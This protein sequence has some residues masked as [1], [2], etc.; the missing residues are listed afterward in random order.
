MDI[1]G[2]KP[3]KDFMKRKFQDWYS[4][5]VT[6]QRQGKDIKEV[7]LHPIDLGLPILKELGAKWLVEMFQYISDNPQFI[8]NCFIRDGISTALDGY[9]HNGEYEDENP[10]EDSESD[11]SE[12]DYVDMNEMDTDSN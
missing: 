9:A 5:Q 1:A 12:S 6:E 7:E 3:A 10:E 11:E 8:V 4:Q 2:N